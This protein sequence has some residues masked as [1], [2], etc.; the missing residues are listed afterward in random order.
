MAEITTIF[1]I[2]EWI[3][4]LLV[5]IA[6]YFMIKIGKVTGWFG[7]WGILVAS[8]ILI[9][10]RRAISAFAPYTNMQPQLV[11]V[12]SILLMVIS[13]CFVVGFYKLYLLF[14]KRQH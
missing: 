10:I 2:I 12:N 3:A 13:I 4:N 7:A 1:N 6:V 14:K 8:F 11:Y 5:L 9:V